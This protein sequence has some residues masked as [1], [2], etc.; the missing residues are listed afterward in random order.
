MLSFENTEIAFSHKSDKELK[1]AHFLFK[2]IS[3]KF[4]VKAGGLFTNL[5]LKVKF[6]INWIV[7]PTIY[8]H[9]VGGE[10]IEECYNVVRKLEKYNVKAIL[11]FSVE[12]ISNEEN[13][14]NAL[15]E[16]IKSIKNA[17]LDDNIPFAVFKPT[18]FA[19]NNI[20]QIASEKENLNKDEIN[21]ANQF[22]SNIDLLCKTA[23]EN[24]IPILIDAEDFKFQK[25]IDEVIFEMMEKYNRTRAIV[26]NTLQMYRTDRLEFLKA[27]ISKA[28][29]K[30]Y[31]FGAKFVR[32]AYME[33]ERERALKMNYYSPIYSDKNK[34]DNAFNDALELAVKNIDCMNIFCGT[35]NEYSVK[36]LTEL[37]HQNYISKKD[38]RIYFSQLYGM[39]DH[40]SFN[41]AKEG[42][43]AAKYLPYGPV[44][45]VIPYLIRRAEENT[46]VAGQTSRELSLIKTELKRRKTKG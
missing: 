11:D 15:A 20:L 6:P 39:S 38:D 36:Y 30:N 41:L 4:I 1:K 13:I 37:M 17:A 2:A 7:K 32:G 9:F 14:N 5:A 24:N 23:F 46:S 8:N 42:Y 29:S 27:A 31:F 22:K 40:L 26:Y 44:K 34:T 21:S 43:N 28:K 12:G 25:F 45:H 16:T 10:T 18:A 3:K 35:H 33:K 19:L